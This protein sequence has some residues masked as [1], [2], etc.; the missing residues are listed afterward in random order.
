[1]NDQM[2]AISLTIET[3]VRDLKNATEGTIRSVLQPI[4]DTSQELVP[5]D[6]GRLKRS[7]YLEVRTVG[8]DIKGEVGYG[9]SGRPEYTALVHENL[10]FFHNPPTQAKFLEEA[11]NRHVDKIAARVV[12]ELTIT[13]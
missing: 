12:S 2:K 7:G 13:E 6:T 3:L 9:K 8:K 4:F 11:V 10:A 1:M 5:V